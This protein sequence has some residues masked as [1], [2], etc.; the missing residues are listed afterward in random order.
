MNL[1]VLEEESPS[2]NKVLVSKTGV[3]RIKNEFAMKNN[4]QKTDKWAIAVDKDELPVKNIYLIKIN[5]SQKIKG[6]KMQV[7]NG[8]WTF[9]CK[10]IVNE[11]NIKESVKCLCNKFLKDKYQG[12]KISIP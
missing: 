4:F 11:L 2:K 6:R 12:F 8:S 7:I 5:N 9:I 1:L 10:P 3:I